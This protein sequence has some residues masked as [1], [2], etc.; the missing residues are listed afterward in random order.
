MFYSTTYD[1]STHITGLQIGFG[2]V[3]MQI[4]STVCRA[5]E[6]LH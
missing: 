5:L 4:M 3:Y 2:Y 6:Q 1:L